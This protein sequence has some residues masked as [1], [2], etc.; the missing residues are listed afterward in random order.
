MKCFSEVSI[1]APCRY[2][3]VPLKWD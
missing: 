1:P 2:V 3:A